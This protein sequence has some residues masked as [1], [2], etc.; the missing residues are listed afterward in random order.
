MFW[1]KK[2]VS[3][4]LM[5]MPCCMALLF[6][7]LCLACAANRKKTG[8][9]LIGAAAC[10]LLLFSNKFVSVQLARPLESHYPAIPELPA[11]T[12]VPARIAGCRYIAV[13][14]SGNS[15][16]PGLSA[17]NELSNSGLERAV[18]GV[19]LLRSLPDAL[20]IVSGPGRPGEKSNASVVAAAA[21]SLGAEP[22]RIV[23]LESAKDTEEESIAI[24]KMVAGAR[25]ALVTSAWHMPR[26]ARLFKK[27][28][29]DFVA[30]PTDFVSRTG[31]D[32]RWNWLRF[33]SE[34]LM[35]S[36]LAVH[37][38]IGLAWLRLR[39]VY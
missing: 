24:A 3:F 36:T 26:A 9:R 6:G 1:L 20:L 19:R 10:M 18:E 15:N 2:V 14:G 12:P 34:A 38:G 4:W 25:T 33:D 32:S 31:E 5:P 27:A 23:L 29:I 35:R 30:C 7:G 22:S 28:G 21:R 16:S 37:E 13:L 39:G 11:N 8:L 17:T